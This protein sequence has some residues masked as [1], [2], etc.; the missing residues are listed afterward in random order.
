MVSQAHESS[1]PTNLSESY[2]FEMGVLFGEMAPEDEAGADDADAVLDF[3][4]EVGLRFFDG[5]RGAGGH[6]IR[7][8]DRVETGVLGFAPR[9]HHQMH[10]TPLPQDLRTTTLLQHL[11][12]VT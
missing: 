12:K 8:G 2:P 10:A 6:V 7:Q 3:H 4:A 5:E 1:G 9:N 11:Q